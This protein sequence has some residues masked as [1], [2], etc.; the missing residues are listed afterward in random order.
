MSHQKCHNHHNRVHYYIYNCEM[1]CVCA[2][3]GEE[4]VEPESCQ[5]EQHTYRCHDQ[6]EVDQMVGRMP[7]DDVIA[8]HIGH[9]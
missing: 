1:D 9:T 2:I 8:L 4:Y 5:D 7:L 3:I 6:I